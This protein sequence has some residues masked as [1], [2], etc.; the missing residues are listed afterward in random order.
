[1]TTLSAGAHA[2]KFGTWIRDNRDANRTNAN[3]NGSF[4]F[5]SLQA[6]VATLNGLA[7]GQTFAQIKA[8]CPAS[9][10]AGAFLAI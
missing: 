3:F 7:Q 6:Y 9:Q 5:P 2:I 4:S 10:T 1:M 8:A